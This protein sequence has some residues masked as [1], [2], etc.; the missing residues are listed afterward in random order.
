MANLIPVPASEEQAFRA[1]LAELNLDRSEFELELTEHPPAT[2]G[3]R[4][5]TINVIWKDTLNAS[6]GA[7]EPVSWV[8][9]FR[10]SWDHGMIPEVLIDQG[11]ALPVQFQV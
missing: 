5:K 8:D 6:Y 11:K 1:L 10:G 2:F 7:A 3:P 4:V 9:Q